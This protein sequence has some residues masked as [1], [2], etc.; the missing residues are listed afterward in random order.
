MDYYVSDTL[1]FYTMN[2]TF[3]S[4]KNLNAF[5]SFSTA[6]GED[7]TPFSDFL[8]RPFGTL[9]DLTAQANEKKNL[10]PESNR[11]V[12]VEVLMDQLGKS[13][14]DSQLRNLELLREPTTFTIT[15]GH[16]LTLFGGPLFLL[17][18]VLHAAKLTE[19]FNAFQDEFKAVPVFWLASEDHDFEEV[20]SARLFGKKLL[21]ESEQ[22]GP[23]GR[24]GL[25]DYSEV[26]NELKQFFTGKEEAE[27]MRLLENLPSDRYAA[28]Y[29]EWMSRLFAAF[30]VL[31]IQPD[32]ARLKR[33]FL[34]V[35]QREL[36][37]QPSFEA[38]QQSNNVLEKAGWKPQAQARACN[39][40]LL[41]DSGR[42]RID[43]VTSGYSVDGTVYAAEQLLQL[44]KEHPEAFSPNVILRPVYQETILPNLVYIGGGGEMAY[45]LQLKGVF[46][47]HDTLFPLLQQRNS[48]LLVDEATEKKRAKTGWEL[49]RF[50]E[51]KESLRKEWL[52]EHDGDQLNLDKV[53]EAFAALRLEMIHKAKEIDVSLESYAEAETV[54]LSKQLEA[55][56]QRL[57]KQVKQQHE[58]SL[59]AIDAVCDR[60]MPGN[61]LQEREL[62]W[63]NFAASGNYSPL[64]EAIYEATDPFCG[65]L[66]VLY[67]KN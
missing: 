24:F 9:N 18:K 44:S 26:L 47:A 31:V 61:E 62:H 2:T 35:I 43:P 58:Q 10:Y 42:H 41:N 34:P 25:H 28:H 20:Q 6:F 8:Q 12:L 50:F 52:Q 5:S 54:R 55:Y 37:E 63:L 29:Q 45:W 49:L 14:S 38:V 32:D 48:F 4:R 57:V 51:P 22:N 60:F 13:L 66:I 19:Q 30:G 16:Q 39:L 59:K 40:F 56:E 1:Y 15:T 7:Q 33:L 36:T 27:I 3:I 65:S 11:S 64:L 46:A 17:Y 67:L 21:W 23:V 53:Q